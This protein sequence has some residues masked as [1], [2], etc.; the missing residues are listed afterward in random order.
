MGGSNDTEFLLGFCEVR[1]IVSVPDI[2]IFRNFME[3]R[4]I[5]MDAYSSSLYESIAVDSGGCGNASLFRPTIPRLLKRVIGT[6]KLGMRFHRYVLYPLLVMNKG[7]NVNHISEHGYTH[8]IPFLRGKTVV[9]VMDLIPLLAWRGEIEGMSYPN[10]PRLLEYSLGFL[11]K[12]DKVITIS[13][14]T[15]RD[16]IRSVNIPDSKIVV[17]YPGLDHD[18]FR[19]LN[20]DRDILAA[21]LGIKPRFQRYL[22]ITGREP[23]K[24]HVVALKALA[25][26]QSLYPERYGLLHI[27]PG[28]PELE[29][30][31]RGLGVS[32]LV[33]ELGVIKRELLPVVYNFVDFLL[34]PSV[35][36]G[37]GWP[38]IEAMACG[39][40][41][42]A[43]KSGALEEVVG[44]LDTT[45]KPHDVDGIVNMVTK[46]DSNPEFHQEQIHRG[47]KIAKRYSW[48][49]AARETCRVYAK[50]L[51]GGCP[52][53]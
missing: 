41:V 45:V 43:S 22:L 40:A 26:L 31:K 36:E 39:T 13:Y 19:V 32:H 7:A 20:R 6:T 42:V 49:R 46:L 33:E 30:E 28:Y 17:I 27:G 35:Y 29:Q 38:P 8:L 1:A 34:F 9:T 10:R 16:L 4:R 15:K 37:F 2:R 5:S 48:D 18:L 25:R 52:H 51:E 11:K 12:A 3:D 23:Y 14:A 24:N 44:D 47:L 50:L 21:F 53:G